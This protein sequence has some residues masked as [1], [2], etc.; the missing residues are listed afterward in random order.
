MALTDDE[1]GV[2]ERA[3]NKLAALG[4]EFQSP[5]FTDR[6]GD[7][8]ACEHL[9]N[10]VRAVLERGAEPTRAQ[11]PPRYRSGQL[12]SFCCVE[13]PDGLHICILAIDHAGPHGWE[14]GK[15]TPLPPVA[16]HAGL[17]RLL[18]VLS[19]QLCGEGRTMASTVCNDA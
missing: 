6:H 19:E 2:M 13:S 3:A 14:S 12:A 7:G 5:R 1:R 8:P 9:A 16:D 4:R 17:I 18:R 11:E 10:E 15:Q